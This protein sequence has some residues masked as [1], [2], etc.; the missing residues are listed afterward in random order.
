MVTKLSVYCDKVIEAGWLFA[1]ILVPL[2]FNVYS[3]RVFEPDKL[4]LLRSIALIMVVAWLI[5]V[6]ERVSWG[7]SGQSDTGT[8]S[9]AETAGQGSSFRRW[10]VGTPMVL[11]TLFMV[12]V[13]IVSTAASVVPSVSLLGSYQRLQGAY[14]TFSYLVVFFMILQGMRN[15]EQLD[16]LVTAV[17]LSSLSISLYG[18]IQHDKL[19]PLPW[20]GDVTERVAAN[21]GNAIFIAAYLIMAIPLALGRVLET[22]GRIIGSERSGKSIGFV[23]LYLVLVLIQLVVWIKFGFLAGI[24]SGLALILVVIVASLFLDRPVAQFALLGG[25][26]FILTSQLVTLLFSQ[27][28]GPWLGF[29]AGLYVFVLLTLTA[30]RRHA[31][32][33][34]RLSTSEVGNAVLFAAVSPLVALAPAYVLMVVLGKGMRWLWLSWLLQASVGLMFLVVLNSPNTPLAPLRSLPYVGR[35]GDLLSQSGSGQ[36]RVLIWE[37]AVEMLS[38]HAPLDYPSGAQDSLNPIRPVIGYGPESMYVAYNRFYKPQLAQIEARNASPDRSHNEAFDALITTGYLGFLAYLLVFGGVFYYGLKCLG[39]VGRRRD[40][41]VYVAAWVGG[42]VSGALLAYLL[43]GSMRFFG[44]GFPLGCV[45][46]LA[47]YVALYGLVL[48]DPQSSDGTTDAGSRLIILA[49]LAAVV[50]HY[51]EI[52][53]GIAIAATRTHFWAYTAAIVAAGFLF[54]SGP[55][56]RS[57]QSDAAP[58]HDE[59]GEALQPPRAPQNEKAAKKARGK[60]PGQKAAAEA[61]LAPAPLPAQATASLSV[62]ALLVGLILVTM[63]YNFVTRNFD[64]RAGNYSIFWLFAVTWV[65]SSVLVLAMASGGANGVK[66]A[67]DWARGLIVYLVISL[68]CLIVFWLVYSWPLHAEVAKQGIEAVM[69][70]AAY[71]NMLLIVFYVSVGLLLLLVAWSLYQSELA[72]GPAWQF[73]NWWIYPPLIVAVLWLILT[74]NVQVVLAD[75]VYKQALPYDNR[76]EYDA[77]IP[78]Y[79]KAVELAPNQDFYFLFLGRAYLEKAQRTEDPQQ[80]VALLA[81]SRD[82]LLRALDINPLNTDHSANLAR[83][84]RAWG[85]L[86]TEPAQRVRLLEESY[87]YYGQATSL[88]PNNAQLWNE[89]GLVAYFLGR[90]EDAVEKFKRS[91]QLDPLFVDTYVFMGDAYQALNEPDEA[92]QAHLEAIRLRPDSLSDPRLFSLP[93]PGFQERRLDFYAKAGKLDML[94]AALEEKQEASTAATGQE[95]PLVDFESSSALGN[96][97]LRQGQFDKALAHFNQAI[98]ARADDLGSCVARG[99]IYAQQGKSE[100]ALTEFRR[101]VQL[102]PNDLTS[103]R[104]LGG[105]L[106]QMGRNEEAIKEFEQAESLAPNDLLTIQ[107]LADLYRLAGRLDDSLKR[108]E[109]WAELAPDDYNSHKNLSLMYRDLGRVAEAITQAQM[110]LSL[111]PDDQKPPLESYL[112]QLKEQQ[113]ASQ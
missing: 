5:K 99:Y 79:L 69:Q 72:D 30:L 73:R 45:A 32:D 47:L 102:A 53:F 62:Y 42:G 83:L 16:R 41:Y 100:D 66:G 49:L 76:Q 46:G 110:A 64:I 43:D 103:R 4:T 9:T 24:F 107:N 74:S 108:I 38:P 105:V 111:A 94:L 14:T 37:G 15:R 98:A 88:S 26:S 89:W 75:M 31:A 25:Y 19:D 71:V 3:S 95:A 68:G 13:Y 101:C 61:R 60:P 78:L 29:F 7:E 87:K 63:V 92:L 23:V 55:A 106:R 40:R 86:I 90:Y 97:Y 50:A 59:R 11:P 82:A 54:G 52:H 39:L 57:T 34:S 93:I 28:R 18:M 36:V 84:H 21:M 67:K 77:S 56:R 58:A 48:Y 33:Q 85:G 12:L 81:Q 104:N 6:L 35:L 70:I 2:F 51:V 17:L 20:G 113:K 1:V 44:V 27:S 80:K 109:R 65:L 91:N 96:I 10:L 8:A 112:S 22:M